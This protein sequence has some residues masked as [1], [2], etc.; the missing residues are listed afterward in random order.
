MTFRAKL[1][2][3]E[4]AR[5]RAFQARMDALASFSKNYESRVGTRLQQEK[6]D[7]DRLVNANL[8]EADR[9][10]AE[11]DKNDYDRRK[12]TSMQDTEYNIAMIEK[13]KKAAEDERLE[14]LERRHRMETDA[15]LQKQKDREAAEKKRLQMLALK[16]NLDQQVAQRHTGERNYAALS[17]IEATIN[18]VSL[19]LF[20]STIFTACDG[21]LLNSSAQISLLPVDHQETGRG[22]SAVAQGG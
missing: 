6:Q 19:F 21:H 17:S 20:S 15:L 4:E 3:E 22:S 9:K 13:K 16:D 2:R 18:K 8:A 14:A 11:R 5:T 1:A 12:K 10:R 7:E